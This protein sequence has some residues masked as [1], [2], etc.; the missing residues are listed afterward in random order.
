MAFGW[1]NSSRTRS[2]S[3]SPRAVE[4]L[5]REKPLDTGDIRFDGRIE[6]HAERAEQPRSRGA[7]GRNIIACALFGGLDRGRGSG[8]AFDQEVSEAGK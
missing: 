4:E 7:A 6:L 5:A 3:P 1:S 8:R 2:C